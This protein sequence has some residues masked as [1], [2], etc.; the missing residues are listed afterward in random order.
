MEFRYLKVNYE[1]CVTWTMDTDHL[2]CSP[3][4]HGHPRYDHV[5]V[6]TEEPLGVFTPFL[7]GKIVFMFRCTIQDKDYHLALI[8]PLDALISPRRVLDV[9]LGLVR[10]R[11]KTHRTGEFIFIDSIVRGCVVIEAFDTPGDY[12]LVDTLDDDMFLRYKQEGL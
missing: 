1:S 12:L 2:R 11:T 3:K 6:K 10:L 8:D 5:I 9:E 7:I 4:F